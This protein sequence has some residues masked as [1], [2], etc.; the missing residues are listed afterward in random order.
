MKISEL[1]FPKAMNIDLLAEILPERKLMDLILNNCSKERKTRR[2][3]LPSK[4]CL[5]KIVFYYYGKKVADGK[6]TWPQAMKK[7]REGFDTLKEAG[8]E[9]EAVKRLFFQRQREIS[10][11]LRDQ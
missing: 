4:S 10:R 3:M 11:E 1:N 7:L 6:M 5:K 8:L 2:I 9:R